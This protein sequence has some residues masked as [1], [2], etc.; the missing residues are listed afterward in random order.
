MEMHHSFATCEREA[1]SLLLPLLGRDDPESALP[2]VLVEEAFAADALCLLSDAALRGGG[3][4]LPPE[5]P[6]PLPPPEPPSSP[7]PPEP[8]SS[9]SS[10]L[11]EDGGRMHSQ[12]AREVKPVTVLPSWLNMS[13]VK[14][15]STKL[16]GTSSSR[17][18]SSTLTTRC[19]VGCPRKV[20]LPPGLFVMVGDGLLRERRRK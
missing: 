6:P 8:P 15:H 2:P 14:P 18:H 1:A 16:S 17:L 20:W 11:G 5:P 12:I 10:P 4:P 19:S 7:E 9:P 13:C 3:E